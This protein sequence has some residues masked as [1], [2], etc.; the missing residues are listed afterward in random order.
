MDG[1]AINQIIC[2]ECESLSKLLVLLEEQHEL[3]IKSDTLGLEEIVSRIQ[4]C[5]K[6]VAQFEVERR[7]EIKGGSMK[8][9]I[10]EIGD[11]ELETNYRLIQRV[12]HS[13]KVQKETNDMLIKLGLG[14]STK[15][16]NIIN[17]GSNNSKTYNSYGKLK[18]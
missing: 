4:G 6:E 18:K 1:H 12:L 7:K 17:P 9:V 14:F 11:D 3:L 5:N 8:D 15:M 10:A 13:I 2:N 16:L